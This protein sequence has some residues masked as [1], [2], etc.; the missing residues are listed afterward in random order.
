MKRKNTEYDTES[1][2]NHSFNSQDKHNWESPLIC[3]E[4]AK[5]NFESSQFGALCF[6]LFDY[7][8]GYFPL[9]IIPLLLKGSF[10]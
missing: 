4:R 10:A 2:R 7:L 9:T 6:L 3:L 8:P 1:V 5:L